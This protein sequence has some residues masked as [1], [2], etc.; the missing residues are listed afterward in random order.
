MKTIRSLALLALLILPQA[1]SAQVAT[2]AA[3]AFIGNWSLSFESPQ[4]TLV[5]EMVVT[6]NGGNVAA[7]IGSQMMGT[8]TQDVTDISKTGESLVLRYELDAQG[9]MVPVAL[10]VAPDGTAL[11]DFADG[12]FT[13]PGTGTK[14]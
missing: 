7:S 12:M 3:S 9:Q 8:G 1:V 11:M 10:S 13:M 5:M 2:S 14:Q 6:D 4:G